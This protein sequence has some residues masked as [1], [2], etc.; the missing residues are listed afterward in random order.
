MLSV[1]KYVSPFIG[2]FRPVDPDLTLINR[3]LERSD[4][5]CLRH[6]GHG[7]EVGVRIVR[8]DKQIAVAGLVSLVLGLALAVAVVRVAV[9]TSATNHQ[10]A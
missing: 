2:I 10:R 3:C 5:K 8:D 1:R 9:E 4:S 7:A 6:S